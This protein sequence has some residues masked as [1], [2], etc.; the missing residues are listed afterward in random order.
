[1]GRWGSPRGSPTYE[2]AI[3]DFYKS[4]FTEHE[5][6]RPKAD[7]LFLPSL[8][9][10]NRENID[11]KVL[12]DYCGD[13]ALFSFIQLEHGKSRRDKPIAMFSEFFSLGK[14]VSSLTF[15]DSKCGFGCYCDFG[16]DMKNSL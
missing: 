7:G 13:K 6:W 3:H 1:M 12:L 15:K 10:F 2:P 4:L 14:F 16:R 5:T 9:D 8:Q 11:N